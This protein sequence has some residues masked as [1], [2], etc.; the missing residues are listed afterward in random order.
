MGPEIAEM[1]LSLLAALVSGLAQTLAITGVVLTNPVGAFKAADQMLQQQAVPAAQTQIE[2]RQSPPLFELPPPF[3]L[4]PQATQSPPPQPKPS[5]PSYPPVTPL[6]DTPVPQGMGRLKECHYPQ[7][8]GERYIPLSAGTIKN[9]TK[10]PAEEVA[11]A[12]AKGLPFQIEPGSSQP[13]VLIMH[14]HTTESYEPGGRSWF[15]PEYTS[16]STDG[17]IGVPAVGAQIAAR[18]NQAGIYTIQDVTLHDYPSYNGSYG[19]SHKTVTEYLQKYPS[20]KVVLDIHRDAIETNGQRVSAVADINGQKAAQIM[21]I[22]GADKNGNL[23]DFKKNL[24]FAAAFQAKAEEMFPGL[25]RPVLFD[26]RYYNQDL[27][28][29]SL[30][31][32]VGSH[33]NT[34]QEA[35]YSG[36]LLGETLAAL[37]TGEG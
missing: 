23:P 30:L 12:A 21:I 28:T 15:D 11:Q 1:G 27:T 3:E 9:C 24:G 32:E 10:L 7:G 5:G 36:Q 34:V 19:R 2:D 18:L 20:I 33:G 29:G 35:V 6:P 37:F 13:Q 25:T 16:R 14:T 17:T 8:K 26:Y 22:C 4:N 31:V